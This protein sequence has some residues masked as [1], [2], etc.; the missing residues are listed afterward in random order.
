MVLGNTHCLSDSAVNISREPGH[1][2]KGVLSERSALRHQTRVEAEMPRL[3]E[4]GLASPQG[5]SPSPLMRGEKTSESR[6]WSHGS[7]TSQEQGCSAPE[8]ES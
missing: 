3:R 4:G 1:E 5:V 8:L 7:H 6:R 2:R